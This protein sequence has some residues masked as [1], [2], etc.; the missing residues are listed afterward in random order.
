MAACNSAVKSNMPRLLL[1]AVTAT[2]LVIAGCLHPVPVASDHSAKK[3][4]LNQDEEMPAFGSR[5]WF[6]DEP[7][8]G[9][10]KEVHGG[11]Q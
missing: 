4:Q 9:T 3:Q 11:M 5:I 1:T 2:G 6:A 8:P 7:A 10:P